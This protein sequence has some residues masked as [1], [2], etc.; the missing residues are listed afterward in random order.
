MFPASRANDLGYGE[1]G[2]QEPT[3]NRASRAG[4]W[5]LVILGGALAPA[6]AA[7]WAVP[8]FVPQ[9]APAHV[10]NAQILVWSFDPASPF[11]DVY[12]VSWQPIPNWAGPLTLAGLVALL[13]AWVADRIMTSLTLVCFAVATV[14]LRWRV[15]GTRG[16]AGAALMAAILAMNM[17][18]LFG[19][20]SFMLGACLFSITLGLWWPA[21]DRLGVPVLAAVSGL[22]ALGYFCHVVSLGLTIGGLVVLSLASPVKTNGKSSWGHRLSRLARTCA[23]SVRSRYWCYATWRSPHSE[24]L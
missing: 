4:R 1:I 18:W 8:W 21:R 23:P 7:I 17:A 22:L 14:W 6:L 15:A 3:V 9:D 19:F 5:A 16:L 24:L 13:P 11:R 12:K 2:G 10:Y 20:A